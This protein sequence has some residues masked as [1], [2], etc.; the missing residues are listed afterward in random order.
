MTSPYF[1]MMGIMAI[2]ESIF[3]KNP[4]IQCPDMPIIPSLLESILDT[5]NAVKPTAIIAASI[6]EDLSSTEKG[7][8][9]LKRF[10]T[11][12]I[13]GAPL[14]RDAG[15]LLSQYINLQ[16]IIGSTETGLLVSLIQEN[17]ED[18]EY[19][20]WAPAYGI[21]MRLVKGG[22]HELT[23]PRRENRDFHGIFHTFPEEQLYGTNDVYEQ[24][25]T[26]PKL[27]RFIGRLDDVIV[28]RNGEKFNPSSMEEMIRSHPSISRAMILGQGRFEAAVLVEPCWE[29]YAGS[30]TEFIN[31]IWPYVEKANEVAPGHAKISKDRIAVASKMKP[32]QATPKGTLRRR[33]VLEDY[34]NEINSLYE[35][36]EDILLLKMPRNASMAE[37]LK[38][39]VQAI[40]TITGLPLEQVN[41]QK[42]FVSQGLDSLQI[43]RLSNFV[44]SMIRALNA[45]RDCRS[46]NSQALYSCGNPEGLAAFIHDFSSNKGS[47]EQLLAY[48]QSTR[49]K[50]IRALIDKYT[51]GNFEPN[52]DGADAGKFKTHHVL[53]TGSTGS[54]GCYLL[55]QLLQDPLVAKIYCLNRSQDSER[56]QLQNFQ[57]RGLPARFEDRVEF[58]QA[59]LGSDRLSL[60]HEQYAVLLQTVDTIVHNAWM[61]NFNHPV[62]SFEHP[63]I[64]GVRRLVDFSRQSAR[65]AHIHFVSSVA[66]VGAWTPDMGPSIP[67]TAI[68]DARVCLPQGYGESKYIAEQ[69]LTAASTSARVP[70]TIYRLGQIAGP[71]SKEGR[72]NTQ[73]WVPSLIATSKT[74]G[75]V[76]NSL[77]DMKVDWIPVVCTFPFCSQIDE[78]D[79][80]ITGPPR[81][82]HE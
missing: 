49:L 76:P 40:S 20:E 46:I 34:E 14:P 54:L 3:H 4:F 35:Q 6:L 30:P 12:F 25:P 17:P 33:A 66:A 7:I 41:Q 43:L 70:S 39:I 11:V 10:H 52:M 65:N 38:N 5:T 45:D 27:W 2:V 59:D 58:L 13:G 60:T 53:L 18:W 68:Q 75:M 19:F 80:H 82:D 16:N 81:E 72:W 56:K 9:V 1:H 61:V 48:N 57:E 22:G 69:I 26:K 8:G 71:L 79:S 24:H 31:Q 77:G 37:I 29:G 51:S 73:E 74:I 36:S 23:I 50:T 32:L 62:E 21:E 67:E 47:V 42:D 15:N 28:L 63:H 44:R 78:T 55:H 64:E